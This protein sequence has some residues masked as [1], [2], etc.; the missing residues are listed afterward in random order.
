MSQKVTKIYKKKFGADC[1][2]CGENVASFCCF[3]G[4]YAIRNTLGLV[5][6]ISPLSIYNL[7]YKYNKPAIH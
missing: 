4:G 7:H 1:R 2:D 3:R 6:N 5:F